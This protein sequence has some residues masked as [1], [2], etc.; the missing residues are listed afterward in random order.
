MAGAKASHYRRQMSEIKKFD[1][2]WILTSWVAAYKK[3]QYVS[4]TFDSLSIW[5]KSTYEI[6]MISLHMGLGKYWKE[7]FF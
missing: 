7:F 5:L 2:P 4:P 6:K 3:T 1:F